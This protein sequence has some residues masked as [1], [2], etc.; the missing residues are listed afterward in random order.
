VSGG[1]SMN[2]DINQKI[3]VSDE[4]GVRPETGLPALA[5]SATGV[6]RMNKRILERYENL[7]HKRGEQEMMRPRY[8]L[9]YVENSRVFG[10]FYDSE[11]EL[12]KGWVEDIPLDPEDIEGYI[13][14]GY[15]KNSQG[16]IIFYAKKVNDE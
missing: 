11:E 3:S 8:V 2:K 10:S 12:L 9:F 14:T 13:L 5:E 7:E 1:I 15:E 16:R 6:E 4:A